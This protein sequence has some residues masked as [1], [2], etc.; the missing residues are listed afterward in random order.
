MH[1]SSSS[2]NGKVDY[3]ARTIRDIC[4]NIALD[5]TQ[6]LNIVVCERM[7]LYIILPYERQR[8]VNAVDDCVNMLTHWSGDTDA[9][10][11][12]RMLA[13]PSVAAA[14]K[15]APGE[16]DI[17]LGMVLSV[18]VY[19]LIVYIV[20]CNAF[21]RWTVPDEAA[22]SQKPLRILMMC[23]INLCSN[24]VP[25]CGV[26]GRNMKTWYALRSKAMLEHRDAFGL[27]V[28]QLFWFHRI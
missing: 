19:M 14:A 25:H 24:K 15:R 4:A 10:R 8:E 3:D 13:R 7:S 21:T 16:L 2:S 11:L 17:V 22:D 6:M 1:S 26:S 5:P 27:N 28:L 12:A 23:Q 9:W 20:G 18:H